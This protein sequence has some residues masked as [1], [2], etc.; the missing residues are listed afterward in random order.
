MP[1]TTLCRGNVATAL[2]VSTTLTPVAITT[3]TAAEQT[4]TIPGLQV[5]DQVTVSPQFAWTG[6][7]SIA[8]TR[9]TAANTLGISFVNTT[10][11][12]LTP[13]AG[14]YLLEINRP[15]SLPVVSNAL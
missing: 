15:E 10:A 5:G 9:V 6:L 11:G 13:P 1:S 3:I 14:I 12:S 7:T 2:V 8:G 4:F